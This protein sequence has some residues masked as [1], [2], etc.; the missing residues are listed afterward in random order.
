MDDDIQKEFVDIRTDIDERFS[1]VEKEVGEIKKEFSMEQVN[2]RMSELE[3]LQMLLQAEMIE[4]SNIVTGQTTPMFSKDIERRLSTVEEILS[5]MINNIP[6]APADTT[7]ISKIEERFKS[8]DE[9]LSKL[10]DSVPTED[11]RS[12]IL[13]DVDEKL[14]EIKS[15]YDEKFEA[16]QMAVENGHNGSAQPS[17][18]IEDIKKKL[19]ELEKKLESESIGADMDE[20]NDLKERVAEID[21][22]KKS[23]D[24]MLG[25]IS[26]D[27]RSLNELSSKVTSVTNYDSFVDET[28]RNIDEL[29][30]ILNGISGN[31]L[32]EVKKQID[33][34]N[35]KIENA[36]SYGSSV[37]EIKGELEKLKKSL[38]DVSE[39]NESIESIKKSIELLSKNV[40]D[41]EKYKGKFMVLD[42]LSK[43]VSDIEK[44][45][46][47][48]S[49]VR[50]LVEKYVMENLDKFAKVVDSKFPELMSKKDLE[51]IN[52]RL[53]ML[54]SE[55]ESIRRKVDVET[56][57]AQDHKEENYHEILK[58]KE[59]E[60]T[61]KKVHGPG[62]IV[63][64]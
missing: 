24:S 58:K 48:E 64:E 22:L 38:N 25:R 28:K 40:S 53:K 2:E 52:A 20:L 33:E 57:D 36:S 45:K 55:I 62:P 44:S 49:R 35:K 11:L 19:S 21:E 12:R 15:I 10:R 26:A 7:P 4:L 41:I 61:T 17:Y 46:V 3:D 16:L 56:V 47:S 63:I 54:F 31:D 6:S 23:I 29:K 59:M 1:K 43:M 13:Q 32:V 42:K 8:Y 9:I 14:K 37:N 34:M 5:K 50:G 30:K 39:V 51:A 27:E 18:D 60:V